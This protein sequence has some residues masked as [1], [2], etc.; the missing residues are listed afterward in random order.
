[1]GVTDDEINVHSFGSKAAAPSAGAPQAAA[2]EAAPEPVK[3]KEAWD[4]KLVSFAATAKIKVI[5]EVRTVT[6][7][8]LKEVCHYSDQ[9]CYIHI[10]LLRL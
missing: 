9:L 5:K 7:L 8:G 2:A 3:V 1:M 4:L 6:S 10:L